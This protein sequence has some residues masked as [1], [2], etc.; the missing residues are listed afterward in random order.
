MKRLLVVICMLFLFSTPAYAQEE[1]I[2]YEKEL[3]DIIS[4]Y[5]IDFAKIKENYADYIKEEIKFVI[6]KNFSVPINL[7][8]RISAVLILVSMINQFS[9]SQVSQ[10]VK[11]VNIIGVLVIFKEIFYFIS[12]LTDSIGQMFFEVKNFMIA[13]L[14]VFAG[15]SF[16][17]G[18]M[19]TSTLYTGVFLV[20][21]VTVANFCITYIVPSTGIFMIIGVTS[22]VS[23]AINLQ[24]LCEFY[25]KA[26]KVAMTAAVSILCFVLSLQTTISQSQDTLALKTGKAIITS[27]VPVI[28]STL[29]GAMGSIYASMGVMKGFCGIAGI[30]VILNIF[31]PYIIN[32]T[33]NWIAFYAVRT[34]GLMLENKLCYQIMNVFKEIIEILF[35]MTVLFMVLLLFSISIMIKMFQGV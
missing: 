32:L 35:S 6:S 12:E 2:V 28:G 18:E 13:F 24:P 15:I 31:L 16:V 9:H 19:I 14:P 20:S 11:I 23:S 17:S 7:Y 22:S 5:N 1:N 8:F 27:A 3:N 30:A 10:T 26:V 34:M 21:I 29:Q 25:S 4:E 33:V